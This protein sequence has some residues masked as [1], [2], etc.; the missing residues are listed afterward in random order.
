ATGC[1]ASMLSSLEGRDESQARS[2][3]RAPSHSLEFQ[4]LTDLECPAVEGCPL[5]PLDGLVERAHLPQPVPAYELLGLRERPVDDAAPLAVEP[6]ALALRARVEA[7][8]SDYYRRLGQF[9]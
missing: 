6:N 1:S 3:T 4:N 5:E 7:A 2:M 8:T 9:F